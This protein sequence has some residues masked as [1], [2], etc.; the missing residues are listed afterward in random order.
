MTR[1]FHARDTLTAARLGLATPAV[2]TCACCGYEQDPDDMAA[3]VCPGPGLDEAQKHYRGP[4]CAHCFEDMTTCAHCDAR[5]LER[6]MWNAS[7]CSARCD[8]DLEYLNFARDE[9][10]TKVDYGL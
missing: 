1:L 8:A 7:V 9:R 2:P 6:D 4:I 5:R 3:R 10:L